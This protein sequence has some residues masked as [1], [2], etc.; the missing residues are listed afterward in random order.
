MTPKSTFACPLE[1]DPEIDLD[2]ETEAGLAR[3]HIY[4]RLEDN[5]DWRRDILADA[6]SSA[7]K[8]EHH[9]ALVR[10]KP[11]NSIVYWLFAFGYTFHQLATDAVGRVHA[12]TDDTTQA[13]FLPY[14]YQ[15]RDIIVPI[16]DGIE[17]GGTFAIDKT[18]DM[19]IS[20]LVVAGIFQW[21]WL[22]RPGTNFMAMSRVEELVDNPDDPDSLFYKMDYLRARLPNWQLPRRGVSRTSLKL[23]NRDTGSTIVGRSTTGEQGRA[24]R[25]TAAFVDEA[26]MIRELRRIHVSLGQTTS[27][28]I[29]GSTA[30]GPTFFAELVRSPKVRVLRCPWWNHPQKGRGRAIKEDPETGETSVTSPW[31]EAQV[32]QAV[33]RR[34]VA[35][36][37]DMDHAGAGYVFFDARVLNRHKDTN[38]RDPYFIGRIDWLGEGSRDMALRA[39]KIED[40][41]WVDDDDGAWKLWL[42][43]EEDENGRWRPPQGRS[44]V[45]GG[46]IA[47]GV[48]A[49]NSTLVVTDADTSEQVAEFAS[50]KVGPEEFARLT[51]QAGYWFGGIRGCGFLCWEANGAGGLY[52][53]TIVETLRYPWIYFQVDEARK[54]RPRQEGVY[55]WHSN[56]QRKKDTLGVFR[57]ALARS[58]WTPRSSILLDEAGTYVF[59]ASGDVAPG[60]LQEEGPEAKAT[61]G[62]RVIAG[63]LS[64]YGLRFAHLCKPPERIAPV[65]S[66]AWAR[67]M[68]KKAKS[69]KRR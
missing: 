64:V 63:M 14:P 22:F 34:E 43:L 67:E 15:V 33:D 54:D 55:G 9:L 39:R 47:F 69:G 17:N 40:L 48:A 37:L 7:I 51:V 23:V 49:A 59:Q 4:T 35:Q 27:C 28:R 30:N 68:H 21:Y 56:P 53:K 24:G 62:D 66:P 26:A 12:I 25:R 58:E 13:L 57:S 44:Y 16:V 65:G 60:H 32:A 6:D 41:A 1:Y 8:R 10:G 36:E 42:D 3:A 29:Y 50:A 38:C 46:D 18:R 20:W 11:P 2:I 61:H 45:L 31:Y 52:G 5:K 19:G